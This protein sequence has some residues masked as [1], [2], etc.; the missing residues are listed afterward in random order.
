MNDGGICRVARPGLLTIPSEKGVSTSSPPIPPP[1]PHSNS[2]FSN[3][4]SFPMSEF[5]AHR[6]PT[7]GNFAPGPPVF[8]RDHLLLPIICQPLGDQGIILPSYGGLR[9]YSLWCSDVCMTD[10]PPTDLSP[11]PLIPLL[12]L[13][14]GKSHCETFW[15]MEQVKRV[16][17]DRSLS[18]WLFSWP[19]WK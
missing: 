8:Q 19:L 15:Q 10:V 4:L 18:S 13:T 9:K 2:Y 17:L 14:W 7:F 11:I 1:C 6:I 3:S 16:N 5:M 12:S